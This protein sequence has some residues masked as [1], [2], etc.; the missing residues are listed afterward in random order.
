MKKANDSEFF[1]LL[2]KNDKRDLENFLLSKGKE[3]KPICPIMF[4]EENKNEGQSKNN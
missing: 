1:K 3:P 4:V 2:L